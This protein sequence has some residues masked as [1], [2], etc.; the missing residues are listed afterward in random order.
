MSLPNPPISG[1][2]TPRPS[3]IRFE[4]IGDAWHFFAAEWQTWVVSTLIGLLVMA[5]IPTAAAIGMILPPALTHREPSPELMFG[6]FLVIALCALLLG[7]WIMAGWY[8]MAANQIR[9]IPISIADTFSHGELIP[10]MLGV[11]ILYWFSMMV[12]FLGC[13][14]GAY[15]VGGLLM[16]AMPLAV[17]Q[18]LGVLECLSQSFEKL[19]KDW[20]MA[21]LFYLV[22]SML[23]GMGAY[24][25]YVGLLVTY[26]LMFLSIAIL[27]R[28][29]FLTPPPGETQQGNIEQPPVHPIE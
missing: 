17:D 4:A 23:G 1:Y 20:L 27:Y 9:G 16:L 13:C 7:P 10:K 28:D 15:V 12:G 11:C 3:V 21:T 6:M 14:I 8:K 24:V 29:V 19:K 2:P 26:P 5:G 25:C 22:V 18:P